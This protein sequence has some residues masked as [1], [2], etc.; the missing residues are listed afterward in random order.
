MREE[1][2]GIQTVFAANR[3]AWRRWLQKNGAQK[4]SAWLSIY[5]K[6]SGVANVYYNEAK[7][8]ETRQKRIW[9][10][11]SLAEKNIRAYQYRRP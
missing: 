4:A 11:V 8:S 5:K 6:Q 2:D 7:R 3:T 9:E 1:K 10:T